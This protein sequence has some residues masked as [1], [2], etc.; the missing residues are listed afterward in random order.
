MQA[1]RDVIEQ[2]ARVDETVL[3]TG[4]SGSGK[5]VVA[6]AL[7]YLGARRNGPFVKVNCAAGPRKLLDSELF[8]HKRGAFPGTHEMMLCKFEAANGG[9]IFLD[10]IGDLHPALQ[11]KLLHVLEDGQFSR[12]G[13]RSNI[14]VDVRAI[15]AT[16]RDLERAVATSQFREDLFYRLNVVRIEMPPLRERPEEIPHLINYFVER[17]AKMFGREGFVLPPETMARL[18]R[19]SFAGNVRELENTIKRMIVLDD[20]LSA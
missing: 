12:V 19:R 9:T 20:P 8:G 13:A 4:E 11:G 17:Y 10:E 5:E 18:V 3:V 1:I 16:S 6:R 7:H 15:A 14:K 2:A